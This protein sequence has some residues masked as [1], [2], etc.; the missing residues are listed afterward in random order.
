[1]KIYLKNLKK[2]EAVV[3]SLNSSS[4]LFHRKHEINELISEYYATL[5]LV[6]EN[7]R[8]LQPSVLPWQL[9][10]EGEFTVFGFCLVPLFLF[11]ILS[12]S[13]YL[14][15]YHSIVELFIYPSIHLSHFQSFSVSQL[16]FISFIPHYHSMPLPTADYPCMLSIWS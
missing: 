1:M 16:L 12:H 5:K 13:L 6:F 2:N 10:R 11:L 4:S 3:L 15:I 14:P 7:Q 9:T 8:S